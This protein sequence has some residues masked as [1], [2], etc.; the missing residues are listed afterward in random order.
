[1]T[2]Y[3]SSCSAIGTAALV[4]ADISN[5]T[6]IHGVSDLYVFNLTLTYSAIWV[7]QKTENKSM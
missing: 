2:G 4:P 6:F 3:E 1:M 5:A 7:I